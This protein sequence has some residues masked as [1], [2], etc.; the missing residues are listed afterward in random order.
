MSL[1]DPQLSSRSKIIS[2]LRLDDFFSITTLND[3]VIV[4]KGQSHVSAHSETGLNLARS[5]PNADER[6]SSLRRSWTS[7]TIKRE[8]LQERGE[9]SRE[10]L[11]NNAIKRKADD[12]IRGDAKKQKKSSPT[13][14]GR[15]VGAGKST[16]TGG[17]AQIPWSLSTK[18]Q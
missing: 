13:W 5:L 8:P 7:F 10:F 3:E 12:E 17:K 4:S 1:A 11:G 18:V 14:N 16:V 6:A 2:Q 9:L 15:E